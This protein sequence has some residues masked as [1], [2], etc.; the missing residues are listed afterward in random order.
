ML[1]WHD[2]RL[3]SYRIPHS[4]PILTIK[5]TPIKGRCYHVPSSDLPLIYEVLHVPPEWSEG[6]KKGHDWGTDDM[7][8]YASSFRTNIRSVFLSY[9][10]TDWALSPSLRVQP[11]A[12]F[13]SPCGRSARY[14]RWSETGESNEP[15]E[16][17][18]HGESGRNGNSKGKSILFIHYIYYRS[19]YICIRSTFI[20]L[21]S[22][23]NYN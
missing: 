13:R 7:M 21:R 22:P 9:G 3:S 4:I 17:P 2:G 1:S 11:R 19:D 15:G 14:V 6:G 5:E 12:S 23:C 20:H 18:S 16:R 8:P 10:H